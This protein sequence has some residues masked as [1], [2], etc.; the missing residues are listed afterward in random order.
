MFPLTEVKTPETL[1]IPVSPSRIFSQPAIGPHLENY[2]IYR[3]S[4]LPSVLGRMVQRGAAVIGVDEN[5]LQ[6]SIRWL[7]Q[8]LNSG[9]TRN[10]EMPHEEAAEAMIED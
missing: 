9:R 3:G 10:G 5:S 6:Y 4:E 7:E 2:T 1:V 8:R